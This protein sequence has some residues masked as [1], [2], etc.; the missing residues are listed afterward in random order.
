MSVASI[1]YAWL[2]MIIFSVSGFYALFG[3]PSDSGVHV[4]MFVVFGTLFIIPWIFIF[5][6][7][8]AELQALGYIDIHPNTIECGT[9]YAD[10]GTKGCVTSDKVVVRF[11]G[12]GIAVFMI[13]RQMG[14]ELNEVFQ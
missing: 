14:I 5:F 11:F 13:L 4:F 7:I 3:E 8:T 10:N 6:D 9:P 1:T 2:L 12:S